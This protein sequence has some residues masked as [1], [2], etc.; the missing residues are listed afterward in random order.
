MTSAYWLYGR[1]AC[2]AALGNP[3]RER[4]EL[5]VTRN[6]EAR[7]R[8]EAGPRVLEACPL[9][10]VAPEAIAR[11]LPAGALH[12]GMALKVRPL[13]PLTREDIPAL[14]ACGGPLVMLDQVSDPHNIGAI[15]RSAAAFGAIGIAMPERHSP[16]ETGVMAKAASGALESLP[17]L[18]VPNMREAMATLKAHGYWCVGLD[19]RAAEPL[20]ALPLTSRTALVLGSEGGGLR[21]LTAQTCDMLASLE[22]EP[23]MPSLNVSNAAAVA[24]YAL[25]RATGGA[26]A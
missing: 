7:L 6:Q 16:T 24:L 21:R 15:M 10:I 4:F 1:H 14:V 17:R 2:M 5:R 13:A 19:G 23:A 20:H 11:V 3:R 25:H 26:R 22:T 9:S 18:C 12:Q 8:Q